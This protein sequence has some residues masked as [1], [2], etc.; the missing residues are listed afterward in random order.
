MSRI[1]KSLVVA[2]FTLSLGLSLA[3]EKQASP[4]SPGPVTPAPVPQP[5]QVAAASPPHADHPE[6]KVPRTKADEAIRLLQS[7]AAIV[8]DVRGTDAFKTQ[9]IVGATD[10]PLDRLE[11]GDFK[12]LPRNKAIIAYCA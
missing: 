4:L 9:H 1:R 3:C 8:I 11:K 10:F 5:T 7:G 6:D 12:G 2:T